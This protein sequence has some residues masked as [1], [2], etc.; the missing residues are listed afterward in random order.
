MDGLCTM[1]VCGSSETQSA[2]WAPVSTGL[3]DSIN[4]ASVGLMES[5]LFSG[6]AG[7]WGRWNS[8]TFGLFSQTLRPIV[9]AWFIFWHIFLMFIRSVEMSSFSFQIFIIAVFSVS[10]YLGIYQYF[11]FQRN[12][13][14]FLSFCTFSILLICF[15]YFLWVCYNVSNF[16]K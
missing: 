14:K 13:L 11:F 12:N 4:W 7:F 10:H 2:V 16:L 8:L 5:I 15:Y 1:S 6:R 3:S 9:L